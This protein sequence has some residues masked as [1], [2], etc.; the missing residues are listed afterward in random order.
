M[1]E[2]GRYARWIPFFSGV[3]AGAAGAVITQ[4]LTPRRGFDVRLVGRSGDD[5]GVWPVV[6]VPGMLGSEL[7][8][9]DGTQAWLNLGNALGHHD[10]SLPLTLPLS[11]S[12]D[13]LVAGGLL[14]VDGVLPRLFGFTEYA[15]ILE[16][17]ESAGF[18][19]DRPPPARRATFHVFNYDWRRDLVESAR[20]LHHFLEDLAEEYGDPGRRFALVGHSMGGLVTR[21]YLRYGGAEPGGP[22]TWAGASRTRSM[23][24]VATPSGGSIH[25]LSA[26]LNGERVGLSATTL[27]ADVIR[28]M[29]A[30]YQLLPPKRT[31]ALLDEKGAPVHAD[32]HDSETWRRFGWGPF[33]PAGAADDAE[34]APDGAAREDVEAFV[35]AALARAAA[36]HEGLARRPDTP[37]PVRVALVGGH[38]LPTLARTVV[39]ER[40]GLA[41]RFEPRSPLEAEAMLE[42]GDGRVTRASLLASHLPA[43]RGSEADCGIPEADRTFLGCAD[44]HG[45]YSEPTF[46]G[47]LLR[48]WLRR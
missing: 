24:L 30:I 6:I 14:G 20:R 43:S 33:A 35:V 47:M 7:V 38:C 2:A 4:A 9:P 36:F 39:S 10:L 15:E 42:A 18:V 26:V 37:C 34:R 27:A 31:A 32:L 12:R 3:L 21:Y 23:T 16:L 44:H 13:E 8:R 40:P 48:R 22:V 28:R 25:A 11:A 17:L 1:S 46:Q 19:R 45:I 5:T 29:P 41:P